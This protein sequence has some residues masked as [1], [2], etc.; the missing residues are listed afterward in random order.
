MVRLQK[1]DEPAY[2]IEYVFSCIFIAIPIDLS[3]LFQE[4]SQLKNPMAIRETVKNMLLYYEKMYESHEELLDS[5]ESEY[6]PLDDS[7]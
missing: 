1:L 7:F 6:S 3:G 4:I 5:S 2:L